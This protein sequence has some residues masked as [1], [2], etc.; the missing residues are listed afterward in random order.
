MNRTLRNTHRF[1]RRPAGRAGV[2]TAAAALLGTFAPHGAAAQRAAGELIEPRAGTWRPWLLRSG[3]QFR[4]APPPDRATGDAELREVRAIA[5]RRD[6]A[7]QD[8]IRY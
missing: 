4:P 6:A 3:S 1:G 5:M 2:A 8:R 7:T